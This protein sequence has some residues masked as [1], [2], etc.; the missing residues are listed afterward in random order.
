MGYACTRYWMDDTERLTRLQYS[1]YA[2]KRRNRLSRY[3]GLTGRSRSKRFCQSEFFSCSANDCG[4]AD[5]NGPR[6]FF[7]GT[8]T[9]NTANEVPAVI[10][11]LQRE[12]FDFVKVYSYLRRDL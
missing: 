9:L 4:N 10:D 11:S 8:I 6:M 1:Y 5:V 2:R 12:G 3:V 7:R